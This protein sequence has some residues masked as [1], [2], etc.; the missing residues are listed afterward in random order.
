[1]IEGGAGSILTRSA[2]DAGRLQLQ[3]YALTLNEHITAIR[4]S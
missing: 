4:L 2:N 1:M 3:L